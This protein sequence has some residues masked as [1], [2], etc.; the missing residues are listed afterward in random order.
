MLETEKL[1]EHPP[2]Y[3]GQEAAEKVFEATQ[4]TPLNKS[5]AGKKGK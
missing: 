2:P 1:A 4:K 5:K 3:T